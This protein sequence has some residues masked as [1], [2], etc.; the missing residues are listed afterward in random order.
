MTGLGLEAVLRITAKD[1]TAAALAEIKKRIDGI[2]KSVETL[3]KFVSS[4]GRVTRATDPL[5]SSLLSAQ[6]ALASQRGEIAGVVAS[7][8]RLTGPT[9]RA[10]AAQRTLAHQVEATT[11]AL[12]RQGATAARAAERVAGGGG[13]ASGGHAMG[14]LPFAGPAIEQRTAQMIGAGATVQEEIA[15]LTAA[16]A[17]GAEIAKVRT[18]FREFSKKY[19]G[20]SESDYLGGYKDARVIAPGEANE[21]AGL[22][23]R[24]KL[25]LRNSG[26]SSSE[27]DVGNVMRIMDELG[28][29]TAGEREGFLNNFT[30]SQQAFGGQ[31]NTETALAAY[32][33][34]KQSIYNWSPE[35]RDKMF[36]TLLQSS[37]Q[38]GGTEMMTA[39]N[40]YIGHHMQE[41]ELRALANAGFVDRKD[42]TV[43]KGGKM[44]LKDGAKLFEA[45]VFK[46]NIA[47]WAWDFHDN[48]MK[49]D[50]A[51]EDGFDNLIAKMPRNMAGLIAF[52]N[53]NRQR[54]ERNAANIDPA[55]GLAMSEDSALA[56]NPVAGLEALKTA[57]TQFGAAVT[58]PSMEAIG[59][60]LQSTAHGLQALAAAY[61]DFAAKNPEAAKAIGLGSE[62]A[63][64]GVGGYLSWKLFTGISRLFGVGVGAAEGAGGA[65][66]VGS[67]L[68]GGMALPV[69]AAAATGG[70]L[71]AIG[72]Y[73][74]FAS[75]W[76][77]PN[78]SDFPSDDMIE[79]SRRS[80]MVY[81]PNGWVDDPEA[82][83]DRALSGLG[84][85]HGPIAVHGEATLRV[86][87]DV[88]ATS[89]LINAAAKADQAIAQIPLSPV[90]GGH[91]GRMDSDAAPVM[92]HMHGAH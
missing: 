78:S 71:W 26:I 14:V 89:N 67:M 77:E 19:S 66:V 13:R 18:D 32:R 46:S 41:T 61:G 86:V 30:K 57:I 80:R 50:G 84:D 49:R 8:D 73:G 34:A 83:R 47:Q 6:K 22:G 44:M 38:Q 17:T 5:A 28:L 76:R 75:S 52:L 72:P 90:A 27:Y 40:N 11:S 24:Y 92:H 54:L 3:D 69:A 53:H 15:K 35:F 20:V 58:G 16:G 87:V 88:N 60:S 85:G 68:A 65:G 33:N 43:S 39:L 48:F 37:G 9:D 1:D 82:A 2:D 70:G 12:A 63:A 59:A 51:S 36:P 91:S 31:I 79:K 29:K 10:A 25:A 7:L 55:T 23:A 45:D 64:A 74:P 62:A 4:V 21:M 56:N 42:L 81:H